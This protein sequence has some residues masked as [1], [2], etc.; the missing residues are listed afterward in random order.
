MMGDMN[1][2]IM[3]EVGDLYATIV[4]DSSALTKLLGKIPGLSGY[5]ER[6]QR[7]EADALLRE[8]VSA[9]LEQARLQLGSAHQ[10]L[11]RDITLGI[12]YAEPLGRA[13]TQLVGLL[14]KIKDAPQGYSG[15]FAAV[16]VRAEDLAR[17][18]Q[19][20]EQMLNYSEQI[21]VDVAAVNK[22]VSDGANIDGAIAGLNADLLEANMVFNS[23]QE[24]LNKVQ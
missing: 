14:S 19:F 16:K 7:R 22:A 20:D 2:G 1:K 13:N 23:R 17:V 9:R 6:D 21:A 4:G 11:A 10:A 15:F 3:K 8:T 12:Q 18:Y 5:L 24:I